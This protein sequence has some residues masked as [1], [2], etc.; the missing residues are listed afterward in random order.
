M[1][2]EDFL[3]KCAIIGVDSIVPLEKG[4][5]RDGFKV[6]FKDKVSIYVLLE[7]DY[8]SSYIEY[9]TEEQI[10]KY[11][12]IKSDFLIRDLNESADRII[13]EMKNKYSN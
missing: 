5:I 12:N 4:I 10:N 11:F 7:Y 9:K 13:E 8:D 2:K 6:V 3:Q 1:N